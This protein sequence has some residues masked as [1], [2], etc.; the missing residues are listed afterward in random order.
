MMAPA[1]AYKYSAFISYAHV[2]TSWCKWLHRQLEGFRI[3]K[4]F[5]GRTTP[6]GSVP[7]KLSIFRDREDFT[8]GQTLADGTV[9]ALD[10]SAA[11][12]VICSPIASTR[13]AVNEEVRLFRW[14]HPDRPVIPVIIEGTYPDNFPLALRREI[15]ADGAV[16]DRPITILGP[17]LREEADGKTIGLAKVVAGL[18]GLGTDDFV[19][20]AVRAARQRL[21]N[22]IIGMSA[23]I[24]TLA[25]LIVWS[26]LNRREAAE[27]RRE[28]LIKSTQSLST[29]V[30]QLLVEH[31]VH[32][33][34]TILLDAIKPLLLIGVDDELSKL[35]GNLWS[36]FRYLDLRPTSYLD[37]HLETVQ[38]VDI[39]PDGKLAASGSGYWQVDLGPTGSN[40]N[41]VRLWDLETGKQLSVLGEHATAVRFVKFSPNGSIL[42]SGSEEGTVKLWNIEKRSLMCSIPF[43]WLKQNVA[44]SGFS[45]DGALIFIGNQVDANEAASPP[46]WRRISDCSVTPPP[47]PEAAPKQYIGLFWDTHALRRM[48]SVDLRTSKVLAEWRVR[49]AYSPV[50]S[51]FEIYSVMQSHDGT[52]AAVGPGLSTGEPV[53]DSSVV[54]WKTTTGELVRRLYGH[55]ASVGAVAFS[56]D[57]SRLA[58]GDENGV[59]I[60]WSLT[61]GAPLI[62][63]E[64]HNG[65]PVRSLAFAGN[66]ELLSGAADHTFRLWRLPRAPVESAP[67]GDAFVVA[68]G[69]DRQ[70]RIQ[71]NLLDRREQNKP[72]GETMAQPSGKVLERR[73]GTS[74]QIV[75][76]IDA[77]VDSM[78]AS[79]DL[80][81]IVTVESQK[82]KVR[83]A[84]TLSAIRELPDMV[85]MFER[86]AIGGN[87][88][89]IATTELSGV[90]DIKTW[91]GATGQP[92]ATI[93][94]EG[95]GSVAITRD[96][97]S[98]VG[99]CGKLAVCF[100]DTRTGKLL[101][102]AEAWPEIKSGSAPSP[103]S[104]EINVSITRN[105]R[106]LFFTSKTGAVAVWEVSVNAL[107]ASRS[108]YD[109]PFVTGMDDTT[110]AVAVRSDL[111]IW[112]LR[113]N[114]IL[115]T[116]KAT[117]VI[118]EL[119]PGPDTASFVGRLA[120]HLG[121]RKWDLA[122][123]TT[124]VE[125]PASANDLNPYYDMTGL[126]VGSDGSA[127][128]RFIPVKRRF[129]ESTLLSMLREQDT[130]TKL[131]ALVWIRGKATISPAEWSEIAGLVRNG[132]AVVRLTALR[133]IQL[134]GEHELQSNIPVLSE[135]LLDP[136]RQVRQ[137][138]LFMLE[139][140]S[141]DKTVALPQLRKLLNIPYDETGREISG[142]RVRYSPRDTAAV[143]LAEIGPAAAPAVPDLVAAIKQPS[144]EPGERPCASCAYALGAIGDTRS[145][146]VD[147]LV[148]ALDS[149]EINMRIQ[150]AAGLSRLG[151][152]SEKV[153]KALR[154]VVEREPQ[155]PEYTRALRKLEAK[156]QS[157]AAPS[158]GRTGH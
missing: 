100:W 81:L 31:R 141:G 88:A 121:I 66:D 23:V 75:T 128:Q 158:A 153:L 136:D 67:E 68:V 27:Q 60:V 105:G 83:N 137:E 29:Q 62:K 126:T 103:R 56:A 108:F 57:D 110:A 54:L 147:L 78:A 102:T 51:D 6:R 12:I 64:G 129:D 35:R 18:I 34:G 65:F 7:Q 20:R 94:R 131:L 1:S 36:R 104:T 133:S 72:A 107:L 58:S 151:V 38:A 122:R 69:M 28:A 11:L 139:G 22:W 47:P 138:A 130:N 44:A 125:V 155:Y 92:L 37:G 16:S 77:D 111:Y 91:D 14:R 59:I 146:I 115:T 2:D 50:P 89:V 70:F 86:L 106:Y 33:A 43:P 26:E 25:G 143:I 39:S 85:G 46:M 48:W 15:D 145:E 17:D 73:D 156:S 4:D 150:A 24:I 135:A 13:P 101:S 93:E 71:T 98:V 74:G 113:A 21:R 87:P 140:A 45:S 30:T 9:A 52:M 112:D 116:W 40:D 3:A 10:D 96:G 84:Q 82:V 127:E 144:S 42:L 114:Q 90:A 55:D 109:Q 119:T 19:R 95:S 76:R 142:F 157:A 148:A 80:P 117:Q 118:E 97:R 134:A 149:H 61:T 99:G 79:P 154:A 132:S 124:P 32:A 152:A 123:L 53:A 5:V 8:G 49:G 120:Q 41:S 63:L